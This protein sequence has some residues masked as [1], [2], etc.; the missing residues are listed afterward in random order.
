M[1]PKK[2]KY[3][4]HKFLLQA[5]QKQQQKENPARFA[6]LVHFPMFGSTAVLLHKGCYIAIYAEVQL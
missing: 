3:P 6:F 1:D 2:N 5:Q 4:V